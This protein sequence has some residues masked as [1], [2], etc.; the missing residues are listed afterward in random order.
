MKLKS[1]RMAVVF[2]AMPL[3]ALIAAESRHPHMVMGGST[4]P[5]IGYF[6]FCKKNPAECEPRGTV[7]KPIRLSHMQW[8]EVRLINAEINQALPHTTDQ[9]LYGREEVWAFPD[10]AGDTEDFALL[11]QRRLSEYGIPLASLLL[12]VALKPNGDGHA[13]LTLVTS[14]GDFILDDE[15]DDIVP[16]HEAPYRFLKRQDPLRI[17]WVKIIDA[18]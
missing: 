9:E 12:T 10:K 16:W 11:K 18:D 5:P 8:S 2:L 3:S 15:T 4:N 14:E 7:A 1:I 17:P 6:E 13:L